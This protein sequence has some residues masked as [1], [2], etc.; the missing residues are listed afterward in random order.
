MEG[1][2]QYIGMYADAEAHPGLQSE[3]LSQRTGT[4]KSSCCGHLS[5]K[6]TEQ[7][8]FSFNKI[9]VGLKATVSLVLHPHFWF[10]SL[11]TGA[12]SSSFLLSHP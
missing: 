11:G 4:N 7:G 8:V 3:T 12:Q 2:I 10:L 1:L 5:R 9:A 6:N